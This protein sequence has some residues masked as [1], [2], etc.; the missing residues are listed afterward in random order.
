LSTNPT[1]GFSNIATSYKNGIA[2]CSFTRAIKM[3]SVTNYF[4]ASQSYYILTAIGPLQSGQIRKHS[5]RQSS[6]TMYTFKNGAT[7]PGPTTPASTNQNSFKISWFNSNNSTF[8]IISPSLGS[9]RNKRQTGSP[10]YIAFGFS[11]DQRMGNDDVTV[12]QLNPNGSVNLYH[13]YNDG[14]Y[15]PSLISSTD[16]AIGYSNITTNV[17]NGIPSCSFT[18]AKT[19]PNSNSQYFDINNQ[20]YILTASGSVSSSGNLFI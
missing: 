6:T 12:C 4:D 11:T 20:Y 19:L 14:K 15:Y 16:P 17:I 8:F 18:R 7:T 2:T 9:T 13:Y 1:V 3:P 5:Y 10:N